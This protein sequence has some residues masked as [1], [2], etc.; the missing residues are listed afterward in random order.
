MIPSAAAQGPLS[1]PVNFAVGDFG[2]I[3]DDGKADGEA[4]RKCIA[5][6][7]ASGR[8]AEVVFSAGIYHLEP[9][10]SGGGDW[11]SLPIKGAEKLI[12]SGAQG[13]TK[14]IFTQPSAGGI[15]F[16][17]CKDVSVRNS[18]DY[19]PLPY[20]F[21]TVT[22]VDEQGGS[23]DLELDAHSI[24][25]D[26]SAYS[27]ENA[28]ALWGIVIQPDA[29]HHTTR[30]GPH[31]IGDGGAI[32]HVAD[33]LWRLESKL[34][35]GVTAAEA[36][37]RAG[38]RYVHMPRTYGAGVCFRNS[39]NVRAEGVT[40]LASPGLAFLPILCGG[41]I[42]LVDCHVR[43]APGRLLSTNADGIH[44]RGLRGKLHIERCSFEGMAD[45]AI[46]I[47]S[48]AILVREVISTTEIV[49]PNHTWILRPS[50]EL[51][52][53]DPDRLAEK[54]RTTVASTEPGPGSTRIR[55]T[56]PIEGLKAGSGF[57]DADRVYNLSEAG[58]PF[59]I[60]D[61]RFLA[62]RGRGILASSMGGI[63]ERNRFENNEGWGLDIAF[64]ERIW[65]E[66]P[67]PTNLVIKGNEFIG[68]DGMQPAINIRVSI[69]FEKPSRAEDHGIR[70]MRNIT[71]RDNTFENLSSPAIRMGGVVGSVIENN[72]IQS[73][74]NATQNPLKTAAVIIDN[75]SEVVLGKLNVDDPRFAGDLELGAMLDAGEQG[76]R[77][78]P[79]GLRVLDQREPR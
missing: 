47:H 50:D 52:V 77:F 6:A 20:S 69:A 27:K 18:I 2:A 36:G 10:L 79:A 37:L 22:T 64:G 76:I 19:D 51:V 23:F 78:D 61:C 39:T 15:L 26:H 53:L 57:A 5:V 11:F 48:S 4:I 35:S 42:V 67:P 63:I 24:A 7:Q 9:E 58:S 1:D 40:I 49:A 43:L 25:P 72:R 29:G 13:A 44:A 31:A 55:F 68:K 54:G 38:A 3:A 59:V 8:P 73:S 17:N 41:E 14:L 65:G 21:G 62:F 28:K 74:G 32:Q 75:S 12:L 60:R 34:R 33:R 66:G 46:N 30:Y 70:P 45:D 71:V 16:E 56:K